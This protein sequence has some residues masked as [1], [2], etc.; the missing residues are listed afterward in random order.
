MVGRLV[1]DPQSLEIRAPRTLVERL[2]AA[3][4]LDNCMSPLR[5]R[6]RARSGGCALFWH[7]ELH[8]RLVRLAL[9][10]EHR[11]GDTD[12]ARAFEIQPCHV[13]VL[14]REGRTRSGEERRCSLQRLRRS[15]RHS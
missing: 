2:D 4:H 8:R 6:V 7:P 3:G 9:E 15:F 13:D 1:L 10:L 11:V 12:G 14:E 5:H